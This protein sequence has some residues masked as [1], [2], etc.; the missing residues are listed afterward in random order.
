MFLVTCLSES[1]KTMQA[2]RIERSLERGANG[3]IT[4][5]LAFVSD[6]PKILGGSLV[7]YQIQLCVMS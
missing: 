3:I 6:L 2:V 1:G 7:S 4:S 5:G